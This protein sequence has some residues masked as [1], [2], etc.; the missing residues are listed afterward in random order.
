MEAGDFC[1]F[2]TC[3][4]HGRT[5]RYVHQWFVIG[6]HSYGSLRRWV[7]IMYQYERRFRLVAGGKIREI[8]QP[9]D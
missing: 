7:G 1:L 8:N 6:L 2:L 3:E 5:R 4:N 9:T